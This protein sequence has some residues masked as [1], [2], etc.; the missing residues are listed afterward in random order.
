MSRLDSYL[1][2]NRNKAYEHA[3]QNTPVNNEGHAVIE[4]DDEWR[5]EHEWDDMFK[6]MKG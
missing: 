5:N 4:K 2:T 6:A 3:S 1:K